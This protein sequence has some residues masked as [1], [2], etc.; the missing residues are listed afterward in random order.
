MKLFFPSIR[1]FPIILVASGTLVPHPLTEGEQFLVLQL[2]EEK[3][4]TFSPKLQRT[5]GHKK[6]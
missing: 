4:E 5:Y 2:R 6:N 1:S 3:R